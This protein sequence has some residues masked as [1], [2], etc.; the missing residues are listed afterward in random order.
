MLVVPWGERSVIRKS[1]RRAWVS[2]T[3][4]PTCSSSIL[5]R[6]NSDSGAAAPDW[7]YYSTHHF[8]ESSVGVWTLQIT[9]EVAGTSGTSHSASLLLLGVP[10]TDRDGDGLD[11]VWEM[12]HFG[13]LAAGP[14]DDPDLDGYSNAREQIMGTDPL[15]AE[16]AFKI[17][18]SL[19]NENRAR[20]SWPGSTNYH[21]AVHSG[22]AVDLL[23]SSPA[24][25]TLVTN[26]VGTFPETEVF[27]PYTNITPGFFR[28]IRVP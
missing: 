19:W 13:S 26:V 15:A 7:T 4:T 1:P 17:D 6:A 8:Y 20:L 28:V 18:L 9:D 11:D 10:I 14:K 23:T 27:V 24:T 25:L 16:T 2:F 22:S 3:R 21:Y 5:A 12:A